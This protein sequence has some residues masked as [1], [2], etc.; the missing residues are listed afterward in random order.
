MTDNGFS[1][2]SLAHRR[3]KSAWTAP[4]VKRLRAGDAENAAGPAADDPFNFS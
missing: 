3:P 2:D 1:S 4:S